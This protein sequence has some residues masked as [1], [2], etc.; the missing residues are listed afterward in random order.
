MSRHS[1][2]SDGYEDYEFEIEY[3]PLLEHQPEINLE[4]T[5]SNNRRD[6]IYELNLF[7]NS[8]SDNNIFPINITARNIFQYID[9][10]PRDEQEIIRQL[11]ERREGETI[12]E[13]II[14]LQSQQAPQMDEHSFQDLE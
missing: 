8:G 13:Y 1:S 10:L 9:I 14:T 11:F 6:Y 12:E 7:M 3:Q 4:S 2:S 5:I